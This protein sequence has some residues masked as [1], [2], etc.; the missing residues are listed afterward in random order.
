METGSC[1]DVMT[2]ERISELLESSK[3]LGC[4]Q[5][6]FLLNL[7]PGSIRLSFQNLKRALNEKSKSDNLAT[8]LASLTLEL[9]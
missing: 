2:T 5:I 1:Q 6:F 7:S 3:N 9:P 4:R 8:R